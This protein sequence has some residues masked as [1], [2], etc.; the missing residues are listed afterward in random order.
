MNRPEA[1]VVAFRGAQELRPDL[2]SYQGLFSRRVKFH[3]LDCQ[4]SA[5]LNDAI[6]LLHS[7][8]ELSFLQIQF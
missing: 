4:H 7:F 1:A 8:S 6:V 3:C 2:R 5:S